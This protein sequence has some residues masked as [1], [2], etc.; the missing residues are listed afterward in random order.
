MVFREIAEHTPKLIKATGY[1]KSELLK[2]LNVLEKK[3]RIIDVRIVPK[4]YFINAINLLQDID[5]DDT[6]YIALMDHIK[7]KLWTGD[8]ILM[9][10]LRKKG[11]NKFITTPQLKSLTTSKR[12]RR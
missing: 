1:S 4:K 6:E 7:G 2:L 12:I 5:L 9:N 11:W 10:G 8:K 3:V